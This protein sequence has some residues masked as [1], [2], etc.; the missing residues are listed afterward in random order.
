MAWQ[1]PVIAKAQEETFAQRFFSLSD[2]DKFDR[3]V[4]NGVDDAELMIV[5][6]SR[7]G[8][9]KAEIYFASPGRR[10]Q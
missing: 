2:S 3:R 4:L 8:C 9:E 10:L 1:G 6:D 7:A 5:C